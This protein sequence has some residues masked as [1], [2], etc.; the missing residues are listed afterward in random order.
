VFG[1]VLGLLVFAY[2]TTR[3]ILFATAWAATSTDEATSR[4]APG[5]GS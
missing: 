2:V 3:L 1:P 5:T 4:P